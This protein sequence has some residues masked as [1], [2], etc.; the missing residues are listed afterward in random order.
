VESA[1]Q[2]GRQSPRRIKSR[3]K[4][5]DASRNLRQRFARQLQVLNASR[6]QLRIKKSA[7]HYASA[8]NMEIRTHSE[9]P[10]RKDQR[11]RKEARAKKTKPRKYQKKTGGSLHP[12]TACVTTTTVLSGSQLQKIPAQGL[13]AWEGFSRAV[14]CARAAKDGSRDYDEAGKTPHKW[15]IRVMSVWRSSNTASLRNHRCPRVTFVVIWP[16]SNEALASL[17]GRIIWPW[18]L[19]LI[20]PRHLALTS[21]HGLIGILQVRPIC[22][23]PSLSMVSTGSNQAGRCHQPSCSGRAAR[24]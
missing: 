5:R 8:T 2:T 11:T 18:C 14:V 16:V 19:A 21:P 24:P 15:F 4:V 22:F 23:S 12:S 10:R 6:G 20:S 7:T 17:C 3:L 1:A 13:V 9:S